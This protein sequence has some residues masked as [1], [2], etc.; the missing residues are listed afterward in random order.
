MNSDDSSGE[1]QRRNNAAGDEEGLQAES[2]DVG[3]ES[4]VRVCLARVAGAAFGEPVDE[5]GEEGGEPGGAAGEGEEFE[6]VGGEE[7]V[8][9]HGYSSD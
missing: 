9:R 1:S 2:A 8:V 5:E 3:D 4:D 7:G 6:V